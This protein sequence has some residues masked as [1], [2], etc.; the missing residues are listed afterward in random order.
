M[1]CIPLDKFI[2]AGVSTKYVSSTLIIVGLLFFV[3]METIGLSI[4]SF[5]KNIEV[6]GL[7][8]LVSE[9]IKDI[10]KLFS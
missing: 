10:E 9:P 4:E 6:G 1:L 3:F 5:D 8:I 7:G 2:F